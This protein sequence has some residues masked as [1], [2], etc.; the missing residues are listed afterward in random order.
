MPEGPEV[1]TTVDFL[2]Q[3]EK[4]TL[5]RFEILTGRYTK[6]P[7]HNINNPGWK[8][9]IKLEGVN[10]KG[11]FIYFSFEKDIHFFS[12]LG[13]TGEWTNRLTKHSRLKLEF[14]DDKDE[15]LYFNDVRNFGTFKII[16]SKKEIAKEIFTDVIS[17]LLPDDILKTIKNLEGKD[18]DFYKEWNLA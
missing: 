5:T 12:T 1:K 9:P 16:L 18:F 3:F 7:I 14:D 17:K 8:T 4:K 6:K 13:M 11:K 15:P 2:K 10:C